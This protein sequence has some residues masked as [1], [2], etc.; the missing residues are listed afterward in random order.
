MIFSLSG[1]GGYTDAPPGLN[2]QFD[3]GHEWNK[4]VILSPQKK[5]RVTAEAEQ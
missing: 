3:K 2:I 1:P 5:A 4:L